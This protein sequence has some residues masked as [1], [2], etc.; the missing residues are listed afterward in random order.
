VF[1]IA[2]STGGERGEKME[3]EIGM[4]GDEDLGKDV[5]W[6]A[7]ARTRKSK[8][9]FEFRFDNYPPGIWKDTRAICLY[10][11]DVAEVEKIV[12]EKVGGDKYI[13]FLLEAIFQFYR[14]NVEMHQRFELVATASA[15][16]RAEAC[17][18]ALSEKG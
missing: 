15:R 16:I 1:G 2:F 3:K 4:M 11:D 7:G 17:L 18:L 9:G 13:Y 10:L 12:I 8:K 5:A 6:E 14:G